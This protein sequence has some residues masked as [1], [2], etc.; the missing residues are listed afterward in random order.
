MG[1]LCI[2]ATGTGDVSWASGEIF[3][4]WSGVAYVPWKNFLGDDTI[5]PH[6]SVGD[7]VL[8]LKNFLRDLGFDGIDVGPVYDENTVAV[9]KGIQAKHGIATDGIVGPLT[10]IALYNEHGLLNIPHLQ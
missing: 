5:I 8:S 10:R 6:G 3:P 9:I 7:S 2:S 4:Y 1:K